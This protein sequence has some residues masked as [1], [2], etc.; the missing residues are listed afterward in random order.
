MAVEET[1]SN[2]LHL[3]F[4]FLEWFES[5]DSEEPNVAPLIL[6]PV[7]IRQALNSRT[8]LYEYVLS[9]T[10]EEAVPNHSLIQKLRFDFG[11]DLRPPNESESLETYWATCLHAVETRQRWKIMRWA[12]LGLFQFRRLLMYQDLDPAESLGKQ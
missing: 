6:V 8:K 9:Y 11:I 1:G 3:A 2:F 5:D 12:T 7:E 4:G 10:G